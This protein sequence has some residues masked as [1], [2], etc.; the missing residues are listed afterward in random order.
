MQTVVDKSSM[1]RNAQSCPSCAVVT[2][3]NSNFV[4]N[5]SDDHSYGF[6][7]ECGEKKCAKQTMIGK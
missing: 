1:K 3:D 4:K 5:A 7:W 6:V 2:F